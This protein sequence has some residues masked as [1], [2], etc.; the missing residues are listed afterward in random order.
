MSAG[1]DLI[2]R[3]SARIGSVQRCGNRATGCQC[4][5][6]DGILLAAQQT[7]D[8]LRALLR[9]GR[10]EPP[11]PLELA[12]IDQVAYVRDCLADPAVWPRLERPVL[13]ALIDTIDRLERGTG[14]EP[15]R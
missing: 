6:C 1:L 13:Q 7:L 3:V 4:R 14:H 15:T 10:A 2:N 11:E 5:S 8:E 12:P 9:Q